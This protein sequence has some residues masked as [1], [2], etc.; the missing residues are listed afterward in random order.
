MSDNMEKKLDNRYVAHWELQP[1]FVYFIGA[2]LPPKAVKIGISTMSTMRKRLR[3]LQTS[4]H[5]PL[6]ILGLVDFQEGEKPMALANHLELEL[7]EKFSEQRRFKSGPGNEWFNA[8]DELLQYIS[9]VAGPPDKYDL[10]DCTA[11]TGPG[12]KPG[13]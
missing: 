13:G 2:G 12:L 8:T 5:E 3:T 1:G 4:N 10:A 6:Y 11:T 9:D 7:H